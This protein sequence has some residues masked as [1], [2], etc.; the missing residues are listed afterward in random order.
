MAVKSLFAGTELAMD[1]AGGTT[2]TA[3]ADLRAISSVSPKRDTV[4]VTVADSAN[5]YMEFIGK[6]FRDGGEIKLTVFMHK[7]QYATLKNEFDDSASNPS[8]RFSFPTITGETTPSRFT[9]TGVIT[10]LSIP[11]RS[12]EDSEAWTV[13][14]TIKVTGKPTFTAGS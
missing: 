8:F 9:F 4:D 5:G 13:E 14:V 12:T 10:E 6:S 2:Y 11:E 7:T 1:P 3:I